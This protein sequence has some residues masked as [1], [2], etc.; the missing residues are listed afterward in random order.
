MK[1]GADPADLSVAAGRYDNAGPLTGGHERPGER[2]AQA[3]AKR[4]VRRDQ[5]LLLFG[6]HRFAGQQRL[7]DQEPARADQA[8]VGGHAIPRLE[9]HEVAWHEVGD[10]D[11][12]ASTVAQNAGMW[13]DHLAD[14]VERLLRLA[15]LNEADDGVDQ[16][17]G[18]DH[19][20]IDAVADQ[21]GR[22]RRRQEEVDQRIVELREEPPDRM[23]PRRGRQ[24]VGT[25]G[26]QA[27][28]GL[29]G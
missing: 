4:G 19:R 28:C 12:H 22:D 11:A 18:D 10:R 29:L 27:P 7:V 17:D 25:V 24:L 23:G 2:H 26:L 13:R 5:I 1:Q 15:F 8:Q 20:G 6:R 21:C 14:G 3:I 9:Q 16:D